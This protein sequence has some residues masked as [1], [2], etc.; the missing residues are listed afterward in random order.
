VRDKASVNQPILQQLAREEGAQAVKRLLQAT[1]PFAEDRLLPLPL[2]HDPEIKGEFECNKAKA[3]LEFELKPAFKQI[4]GTIV[5]Q[6]NLD[7]HP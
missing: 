7:F 6:H 4:S 5:S 1:F 2:V 3:N